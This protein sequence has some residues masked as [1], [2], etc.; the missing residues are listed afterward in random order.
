MRGSIIY[1]KT[2]SGKAIQLQSWDCC[3]GL[4]NSLADNRVDNLYIAIPFASTDPFFIN[5]ENLQKYLDLIYHALGIRYMLA[6]EEEIKSFMPESYMPSSPD[7]NHM[8]VK[9][10]RDLSKVYSNKYWNCTHTLLR[11]TWYQ[12]YH[13]MA[14]IATNLYKTGMFE[15]MDCIAIASSYQPSND[16]TLLPTKTDDLKSIL[17]FRKAEKVIPELQKNTLFNTVFYK[18]PVYFSPEI[19]VAGSFF[20]DSKT[21]IMARD[22]IRKLSALDG[23]DDIPPYVMTMLKN[24]AKKYYEMYSIYEK[25]T[26]SFQKDNLQMS[27]QDG[28]NLGKDF[29][30]K[31]FTLN[32]P[33][34]GGVYRY[35][36]LKGNNVTISD[37]QITKTEEVELPF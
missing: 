26:E 22:E 21:I 29:N 24:I 5:P 28:I 8:V 11:Y 35:I 12:S 31:R 33:T 17:F 37:K 4:G 30:N 14:I 6:E 3:E 20:S 13:H 27:F 34:G 15:P 7:K 10:I 36:T 16:R 25:I 19:E 18:F 9:G 32:T 23:I 2:K 1:Y